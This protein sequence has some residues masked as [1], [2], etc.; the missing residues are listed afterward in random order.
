[1][2]MATEIPTSD[3]PPDLPMNSDFFGGHSKLEVAMSYSL[4]VLCVFI[5]AGNSIIL[6][7]VFQSRAL[8]RSVNYIILSLALVDFIVGFTM[9]MDHSFI[10][11]ETEGHLPTWQQKLKA[12][13]LYFA[14]FSITNSL[15]HLMVIAGDRFISVFNPLKYAAIMTPKVIKLTIVTAWII[16][17][18]VAAGYEIGSALRFSRTKLYIQVVLYFGTV[19][20]LCILYGRI[21]YSAFQQRRKIAVTAGS[22]AEEANSM[23]TTLMLSFV[24][25]AFTLLWAPQVIVNLNSIIRPGGSELIWKITAN[26]IAIVN[27]GINVVIYYFLNSKFRRAFLRLCRGTDGSNQ[28]I[29]W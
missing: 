13:F 4:L 9:A 22:H 24:I 7:A 8:Q 3:S 15:V 16:S 18:I 12:S 11:M 26:F 10:L 20:L 6:I 23:K 5:M 25:G 21:G 2:E 17:F 29:D 28:E 27:S 19:F 14:E 1:M